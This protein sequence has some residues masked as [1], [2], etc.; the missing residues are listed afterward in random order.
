MKS[1]TWKLEAVLPTLWV[2]YNSWRWLLTL[3]TD[4]SFF[5]V[6]CS[7]CPLSRWWKT[8]RGPSGNTIPGPVLHLWLAVFIL[9]YSWGFWN[10]QSQI[11]WDFGL[12]TEGTP[13][14]LYK[15]KLNQIFASDP[16]T[17]AKGWAWA[18]PPF[19]IPTTLSPLGCPLSCHAKDKLEQLPVLPPN[20]V[21]EGLHISKVCLYPQRCLLAVLLVY[22]NYVTCWLETISFCYPRALW[23]G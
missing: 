12:L 10:W 2:E 22:F 8:E 19:A 18:P 16:Y 3:E 20:R 15:A 7:L 17:Q 21:F 11:I 14:F 4:F 9:S 1:V 6:F 5:L 13:F 23:N